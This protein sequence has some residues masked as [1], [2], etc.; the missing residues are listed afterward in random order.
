[1]DRE[2]AAAYGRVATTVETESGASLSVDEV[3]RIRAAADALFFSEKSAESAV[4]DL[5]ALITALVESGRWSE[6]RAQTLLD[7]VL[8]CGSLA[9]A[10]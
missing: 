8:H 6:D 9:I 1:M 7:D 2:S 5:R 4:E 3:N 10:A